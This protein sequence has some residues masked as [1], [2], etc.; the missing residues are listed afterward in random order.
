M[1]SLLGVATAAALVLGS[2]AAF[3][4]DTLAWDK[5]FPKSDRVTSRKVSFYNRLGINLVGDLYVPKSLEAGR[6]A[7]AIVVGHPFGGVKE[8]KEPKELVIVPGAGHVD[9]YDRLDPIPFDKPA[10]FFAKQLS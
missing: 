2:G 1:R 3:G 7:P 10:S 9:L 4:R 6:Q 5:T 8:Q